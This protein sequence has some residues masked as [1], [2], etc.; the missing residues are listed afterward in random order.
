MAGVAEELVNYL[1]AITLDLVT[2]LVTKKPQNRYHSFIMTKKIVMK[3]SYLIVLLVAFVLPAIMISVLPGEIF[4]QTHPRLFIQ[5]FSVSAIF[6]YFIIESVSAFKA[7]T[8]SSFLKGRTRI[9]K[10]R[11]ISL[12]RKLNVVTVFISAIICF[13][14]I[15]DLFITIKN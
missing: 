6:I 4:M 15:Y 9:S 12:S 2:G 3:K 13:A 14:M 10:E 1:A 5:K 7:N 8:I 11:A